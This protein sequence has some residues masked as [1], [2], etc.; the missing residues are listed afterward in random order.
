MDKASSE[1]QTA[2]LEDEVGSVAS[3]ESTSDTDDDVEDASGS[4]GGVRMPNYAFIDLW[5]AFVG[6]VR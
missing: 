2:D 5:F 3:E 6:L 1:A 4:V